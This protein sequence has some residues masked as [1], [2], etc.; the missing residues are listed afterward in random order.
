[1]ATSSVVKV[2]EVGLRRS[3]LLLLEKKRG[4]SVE[5]WWAEVLYDESGDWIS[6]QFLQIDVGF[7]CKTEKWS[8]LQTHEV[9]VDARL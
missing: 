3:M 6:I 8:G 9:E 4:W 7:V 1:M 5:K 2:I